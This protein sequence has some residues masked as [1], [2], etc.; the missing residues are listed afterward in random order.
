MSKRL[1]SFVIVIL[2]GALF[3]GCLIQSSK[4]YLA[5]KSIEGK[6]HSA[7]TPEQKKDTNW[8]RR[9][10]TANSKLKEGNVDLLFIGDSITDFWQTS[11]RQVWSKY[12]ASRNAINMGISGDRTQ[13][14]LW[15]LDNSD[16]SNV[17]PKLAIVMIGTNN[18]NKQDNTAEEIGEGIIA[19]C[20]RLRTKLP[21]TKILLLAIFPRNSGPSAQ[22]EKN[23]EAS[24]IASQIADG[25]M[26]YYLDINCKFLTDDGALTRDI[27]SDY[28]HPGEKGYQIWAEAIEPAV[29]KLLGEKQIK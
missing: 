3:C 13:N 6:T 18:S 23:A 21:Q 9:F 17:K 24:L 12:Y 4:Q 2:I 19:V 1:S 16:F 20:Q 8:M 15:R 25:K 10:E 27:M 28:L 7:V 11:G 22:R 29:A 5:F 26:I 14:V